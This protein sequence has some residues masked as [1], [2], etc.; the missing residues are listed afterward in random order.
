MFGYAEAGV[1]AGLDNRVADIRHV[2]NRL[3]IYLGVAAGC[4]SATFN[5]VPGDR[6]G[7]QA[8][9][10]LLVPIELVNHGRQ[11]QGGIGAAACND[12]MS[13]GAQRL[14]E[15]ESAEISIGAYHAVANFPQWPAGIDVA[16][17]GAAG[18]HVI[19]AIIDIVTQHDRYPEAGNSGAAG[20]RENSLGASLGIHSARVGDHPQMLPFRQDPGHQGPKIASVPELRVDPFL[21]LE[22]R[23]G[24]LSQVVQAEVIDWPLLDQANRRFEPV[25]PE[26]LSVSDAD[27][28]FHERRRER[29]RITRG[30]E[31]NLAL[32]PR[33]LLRTSEPKC[34]ISKPT[35]ETAE[36]GASPKQRKI[37][38]TSEAPAAAGRAAGRASLPRG[39]SSAHQ[40]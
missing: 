21:F 32:P 24:N 34:L 40:D 4:L 15:R 6:T 28:G 5:N 39:L 22:N 8:V 33:L 20:R 36:A 16:Q 26:A 30:A 35:I 13:A 10:V 18:Q 27:D 12:H 7:G 11:S 31:E 9:P 25:A 29:R 17:I 2:R 19:Q 37:G 3:P 14:D 1:G 23:H 38:A